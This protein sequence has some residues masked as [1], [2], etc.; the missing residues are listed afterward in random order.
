MTC[1]RSSPLTIALKEYLRKTGLQ[2][3][4]EQKIGAGKYECTAS[5]TT[6]RNGYRDRELKTRV[7]DLNLRIPK[8]RQGRERGTVLTLSPS[9]HRPTPGR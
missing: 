8:L 6:Q 9:D 5:R 1:E 4:V 2:L 3:E 7:G